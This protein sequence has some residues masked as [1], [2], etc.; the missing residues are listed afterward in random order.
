[1]IRSFRPV[2]PASDATLL[3]SWVTQP[4]A[5]FWGMTSAAVDDVEREYSQIAGSDHHDAFLGVDDGAPAFLVERYRPADSPLDAVYQVR[6]GDVGMHLLVGPP[7]GET[8]PGYTLRVMQSVMTWLFEHT[9]AERVVVEPDVRNH[10]I[11]VLNER[12]G[13]HAHSVVVLPPV[14]PAE[15]R[16][17]ALLSFCTRDDFLATL[18]PLALHTDRSTDQTT[19]QTPGVHA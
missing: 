11:H 2:D 13:F 12:V 7:Q 3:H 14:D 16:K 5:R 8:V 6:P 9:G 17:E 19:E 10:K 15:S 18:T 4:Y 1:M